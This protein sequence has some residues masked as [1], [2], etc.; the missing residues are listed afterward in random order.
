[1]R[2]AAARS[3]GRPRNADVDAAIL[4]AALDLL[5]EHG[6]EGTT[7]EQVAKRAGVTRPT[8]YRRFPDKNQMLVAAIHMAHVGRQGL[9]ELPQCWDVE[10]MLSLW[11]QV[12]C[13]PRRRGLMRRLMTSLPDYPDLRE[14]YWI[15]SLKQRNEW[16]QVVLDQG[17]DR[18]DFPSDADLEIIQQ[19]LTGA[20][21]THLTTFPDTSTKA[22][23]EAYL[24]AVLR[25][26]CY[27]RSSA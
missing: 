6:V 26:T 5:I 27:R 17:R 1:M 3:P 9:P 2:R 24:V 21:A 15:A 10:Q 23:I 22:E 4:D 11:A 25:Q 20:V 14:A 18:G 8:V 7:I 19:I 13:E 12:L 16:I